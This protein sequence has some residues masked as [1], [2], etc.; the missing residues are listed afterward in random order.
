MEYIDFG[1]NEY[2]EIWEQ[3]KRCFSTLVDAKSRHEPINEEFLL[4]GE[5]YPV[6]TLGF[7]GNENNL[8]LTEAVLK[9]RGA[10]VIRI[11]RGGDITYHG[12]GQLILYPILD[13]QKRGLGV[14]SYMFLLEECVIRLLAQYGIKGERVDGATGVW[15]DV[16]SCQER[17]ICAMGVRC[18]RHITMHGLALNVFTELAAFSAINP[19]G[20]VDKGVTSIYEELKKLRRDANSPSMQEV[21]KNILSIFSRLFEE[22]V[23]TL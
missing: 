9:E 4:Y 6:Y 5:H 16:G 22:D 1:I 10:E 3:Q 14:K 15:I 21:K 2:R 12:P 11:E 18:R 19:C 17:K 20:F 13:L 23:L 8:L 7:H